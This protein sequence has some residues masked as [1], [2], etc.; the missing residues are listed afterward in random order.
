MSNLLSSLLS[1]SGALSAYDQVLS[2]TQNNVA[3]ASTPGFVKQRQSLI[4]MAFDP[5]RGSGGGVRAG[6]VQSARSEYAEQAVRAQTVLLGQS[7]QSVNSLTAL[8]SVFDV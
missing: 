1:S 4:A 7:Q 8:Q 5:S 3:N 2:V 6:E